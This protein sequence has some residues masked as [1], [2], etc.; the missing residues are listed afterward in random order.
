MARTK[1]PRKKY[2]PILEWTE[3]DAGYPQA[4]KGKYYL[5]LVTHYPT[6]TYYVTIRMRHKWWGAK[7]RTCDIDLYRASGHLYEPVECGPFYEG[8][9]IFDPYRYKA[10]ALAW[11]EGVI[12][13]PFARLALTL[14]KDEVNADPAE[15]PKIDECQKN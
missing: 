10:E 14:K 12:L 15:S 7:E 5:T 1:P 4:D 8:I 11:A 13:T 2:T 9:R 3:S 6:H